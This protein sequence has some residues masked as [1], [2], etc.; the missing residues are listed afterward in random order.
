VPADTGA[1]ST[2]APL[3]GGMVFPEVTF[4]TG[5]T[6]QPRFIVSGGIFHGCTFH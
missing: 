6:I 4:A 3:H 1:V 2:A 5:H